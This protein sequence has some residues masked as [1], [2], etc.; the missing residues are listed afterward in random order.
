PPRCVVP[1]ARTLPPPR[2]P[3]TLLRRGDLVGIELA[4]PVGIEPIEARQRAVD[5]LVLADAPVTIRVELLTKLPDALTGPSPGRPAS[6]RVSVVEI[7]VPVTV[8]ARE[9]VGA[10]GTILVARHR[11]V[12]IRVRGVEKTSVG[13]RMSRRREKQDGARQEEA[14]MHVRLPIE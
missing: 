8:E 1:R 2:A 9:R 14:C 10:G 12:A 7:A 6:G 4:V 5:E 13:L 11:A 3:R